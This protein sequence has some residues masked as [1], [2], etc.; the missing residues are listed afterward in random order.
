MFVLGKLLKNVF[1]PL[2]LQ[3]LVKESK[4]KIVYVLPFNINNLGILNATSEDF[5]VMQLQVAN[6]HESINST[7]S[8]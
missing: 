8:S 7:C 5:F 2:S 3:L 4:T 6:C 1:L